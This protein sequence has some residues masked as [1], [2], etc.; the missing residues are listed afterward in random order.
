MKYFQP[1]SKGTSHFIDNT[2]TAQSNLFID[3]SR[4]EFLILT[5]SYVQEISH[6][7]YIFYK[8]WATLLLTIV[9]EVDSNTY[10][11]FVERKFK[12]I[13]SDFTICVKVPWL[14]RV[15]LYLSYFFYFFSIIGTCI[16]YKGCMLV[17]IRSATTSKRFSL[18]FENS[19][20][21]IFFTRW[22]PM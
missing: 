15:T 12:R 9:T 10:F 17:R 18:F 4:F 14:A 21:R 7:K 5:A 22:V 11:V 20:R 6:G 2:F 3:N 8:Y 19:K 13:G 16:E 1:V